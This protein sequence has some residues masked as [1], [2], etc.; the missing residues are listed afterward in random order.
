MTLGFAHH[1]T[2][3]SQT[4]KFGVHSGT[5]VGHVLHERDVSFH[6]GLAIKLVHAAVEGIAPEQ[7]HHTRFSLQ[8]ERLQV[9]VQQYVLLCVDDGCKSNGRIQQ[10]LAQTLLGQAIIDCQHHLHE[11]QNLVH[12]VRPCIINRQLG[13]ACETLCSRQTMHMNYDNYGRQTII[14]IEPVGTT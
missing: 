12:G 9:T 5:Y 8:S 3:S 6:Q 1:I 10:N 14:D 2:N 4:L 13:Y 11:I 7:H